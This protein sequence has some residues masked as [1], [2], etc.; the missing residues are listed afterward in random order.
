MSKDKKDKK[1]AKEAIVY[2]TLETIDGVYK[3]TLNE[4]F[5]RRKPWKPVNTNH[6]IAPI[7]GTVNA[8]HIS[9]GQSVKESDI[10]M[11]YTAMKMN[12]N[13]RAPKDGVI[14]AINVAVGDSIPK[15]TVMIELK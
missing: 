2:E 1:G 15:G 14:D 6:I 13:I 3:T 10:L 12:N 4:T 11:G 5:R 7:P 9:V 8:I